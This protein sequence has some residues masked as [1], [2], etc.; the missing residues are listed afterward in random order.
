MLV[1]NDKKNHL[2]FQEIIIPPKIQEE[3]LKGE[4][5]IFLVNNEVFLVVISQ[6][7]NKYP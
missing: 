6:R 7:G 3:K 2:H 5:L 1:Y 4:E